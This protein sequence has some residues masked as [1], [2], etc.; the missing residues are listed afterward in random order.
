MKAIYI[1]II[2]DVLLLLIAI[3]II[4]GNINILTKAIA[5]HLFSTFD[6]FA[7]FETFKKWDKEHDIRHKMNLLYA[8]ILGILGGS[9]LLYSQL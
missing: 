9:F 7:D 5:G 6:D 3:K 8:A 4:F 2:V 1:I